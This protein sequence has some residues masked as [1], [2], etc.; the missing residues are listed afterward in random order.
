[1]S[2]VKTHIYDSKQIITT[3]TTS[4]SW[5]IPKILLQ[6]TIPCWCILV[7]L[8][9]LIHWL[10][11]PYIIFRKLFSAKKTEQTYDVKV[12]Q[13]GRRG[14]KVKTLVFIHGWPDSG[15][16]WNN[17]VDELQTGYR[18]IVVSLP[19]HARPEE[20]LDG[21]GYDFE[22]V[23][24][25]ILD[26]I[27]SKTTQDEKITLVAHDWGCA[28][29][30]M[31][32]KA[33]PNKVERMVALDIGS[34]G[35]EQSIGM[36]IF[37]ASYQLFNIFC[38]LLG[39]PVGDWLLRVGVSQGYKARPNKELYASMNYM[40]YYLWKR[41]LTSGNID[42]NKS[43][44]NLFA[45]YKSID[46]DVCPVYFAYGKDKPGMFHSEKFIEYISKNKLC[47]VEEFE[48][49][50]WITVNKGKEVLKSINFF[51]RSTD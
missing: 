49:D 11:L 34:G 21:W 32:Q 46:V 3:T 30:Y 26:S 19:G 44:R 2:K 36:Y 45:H 39:H 28:F 7:P 51:L 43:L 42:P 12:Y 4:M 5:S 23:R 31:V 27:N 6:L 14:D 50:H 13:K 22:D 18:C 16:L 24:D 17:I 38:F 29:A 47:K 37:V 8:G 10:C 35:F 20:G 48:C 15:A 9:L 33:I 1:M 40:Y 41:F 25:L